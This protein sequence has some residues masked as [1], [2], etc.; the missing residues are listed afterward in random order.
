[1]LIVLWLHCQTRCRA[2]PLEAMIAALIC[3]ISCATLIQFAISQWRSIWLTIAA[4]PL[5]NSFEAATG[6]SHDSVG[7]DHFEW[8][9]RVTEQKFPSVR[10]GQ[11]WLTAIG[12]YRKGLCAFLKIGGHTLPSVADWVKRELTECSKYAAA[13]L[14]RRLNATLA[15]NSPSPL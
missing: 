13:T 14:D 10:D 5:S 8:L 7:P 9:V 6:I 15:C 3:V 12:F 1:M 4:Q 11:S 2:R